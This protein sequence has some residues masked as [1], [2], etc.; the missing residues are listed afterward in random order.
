MAYGSFTIERVAEG[1]ESIDLESRYTGVRMGI[2]ESA[3][4]KLEGKVSYGGL[5]FNEDNYKNTRRIVENTSTT[6]EGIVGKEESPTAFVRIDSS[7]GT[8]RLN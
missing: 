2:D 5:K 3:S 7:Y 1:F 6:V 4:Y 8:I